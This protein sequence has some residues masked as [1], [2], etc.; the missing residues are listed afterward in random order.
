MPL[1]GFDLI[2]DGRP[3]ARRASEAGRHKKNRRASQ[4]AGSHLPSQKSSSNSSLLRI[5]QRWQLQGDGAGFSVNGNVQLIALLRA[6]LGEV[7]TTDQAAAVLGDGGDVAERATGL[8]TAGTLGTNLDAG[9]GFGDRLKQRG[10]PERFAAVLL[11]ADVA[12]G[13]GQLGLVNVAEF[14]NFLQQGL[15]REASHEACGET[16]CEC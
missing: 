4:P 10:E 3:I 13:A 1:I 14:L 7:A 12:S 9:A 2:M 5:F 11:R 6:E 15:P 8:A 16:T